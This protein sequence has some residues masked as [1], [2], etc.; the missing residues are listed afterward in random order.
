V[1]KEP[2]ARWHLVEADFN[3]LVEIFNQ[4]SAKGTIH[5]EEDT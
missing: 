2:E 3:P 4:L 5:I 1:G